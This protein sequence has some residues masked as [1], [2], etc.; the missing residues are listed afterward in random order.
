MKDE[1]VKVSLSIKCKISEKS[2]ALSLEYW[3]DRDQRVKLS[4]IIG[5]EFAPESNLSILYLH[6]FIKVGG[7]KYL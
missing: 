5:V 7:E 2:K 1:K 3:P 6:H 4:M